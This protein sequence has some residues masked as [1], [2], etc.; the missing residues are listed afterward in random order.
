M[1]DAKIILKYKAKTKGQLVEQA[2]KLVNAF[3]RE[4]DAINDKG[5]FVCISCGKYKPKHQCNA[6]HYFSR[7]NYPSVR[8]DLDN[9]HS[10]CI[11]CNLHQHGN[12]IPYRERLI[13][14]IGKK[15]FEQLEKMAYISHYKHDR[16]MLIELIERMKKQLKK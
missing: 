1:I 16:I 9:I 15:R 3:V 8:F 13:R 7:G 2:Q 11:Q 10:Q 4:R 12:L 5:D 14:K 6:G